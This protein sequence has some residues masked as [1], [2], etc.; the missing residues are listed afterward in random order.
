MIFVRITGGLGNQMFQYAFARALQARGRKVALQWHGHRTK[1]RHNGCEL[2]DVFDSPLSRKIRLANESP[3]L[4]ARAWF[5]RKTG[6]RREPKNIGYNPEFLDATKG[7][8]DGYWQTEKYF[9]GIADTIRSDFRFKPLTG[10]QNLEL[11]NRIS[12]E[13]CV[14]IHVRRGDYINHP[15]L[16]DVCG[17]E[18]YRKALAQMDRNDPGKTL[19]VFSDDIP[20]CRTL[21]A[22]RPSVFVDWN[23]SEDS[24]MDMALMSRCT[25]HIIANSSFSWWGAWLNENRTGFVIAPV[26]WFSAASSNTNPDILA[27]NWKVV[28]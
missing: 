22:D 1:S 18:Y 11:L 15:G 13:S 23:R 28:D 26:Q 7:Y 10:D 17:P 24:W 5:A 14:S 4:N 6:R 16:S 8:L 3:L 12:S 21:F 9:S 25:H 20:Y 2:D 19:V 27:R